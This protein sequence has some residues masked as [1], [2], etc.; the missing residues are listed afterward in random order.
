MAEDY[1][2]WLNDGKP[3]KSSRFINHRIGPGE[4][5]IGIYEA[6]T[7]ATNNYGKTMHYRFIGENGEPLIFDSNNRRIAAAFIC[8]PPKARVS[9]KR[10]FKNGKFVFDVTLINTLEDE[11]A[12]A[13]LAKEHES[14]EKD[15]REENKRDERLDENEI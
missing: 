10:V 2:S 1:K 5:F 13:K 6:A 9:I 4:E 11:E 12:L 15:K 3:K 8:F 14:K 7:K